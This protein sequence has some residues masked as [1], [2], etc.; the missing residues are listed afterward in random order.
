MLSGTPASME[1]HW[2]NRLYND[3]L[4]NLMINETNESLRLVIALLG[5]QHAGVNLIFYIK[6]V[7]R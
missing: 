7:V 4:S 1:S 2:L 6:I 5:L 3:A